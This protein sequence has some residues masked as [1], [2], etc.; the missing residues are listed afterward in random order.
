MVNISKKRQRRH[1]YRDVFVVHC[2][3]NQYNKEAYPSRRTS[4][5]R[6]VS[7]YKE[8]KKCIVM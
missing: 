8:E 5:F 1:W 7:C 3:Y 2:R 4:V 6:D